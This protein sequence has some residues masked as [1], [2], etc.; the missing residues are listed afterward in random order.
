MARSNEEQLLGTLE[1][2]GEDDLKT[3]QWFLKKKVLDG[4]DP[5]PKSRLEGAARTDTVDRMVDTY[6]LEGALKITVEILGKMDQNNLAKW[7]MS[8]C[9]MG[10]ICFSFSQIGNKNNCHNAYCN[11]IRCYTLYL[12]ISCIH[13]QRCSV[14]EMFPSF[15]CLQCYS[16][17]VSIT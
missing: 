9:S 14:E 3:F 4:F 17:C 16:A 11:L 13:C 15:L 2:L 10:I 12:E 6:R 7:L 1:K 8:K 5:I